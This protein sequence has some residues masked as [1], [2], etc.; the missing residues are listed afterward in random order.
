MITR[1]FITRRLAI[2]DINTTGVSNPAFGAKEV[3]WSTTGEYP[4]QIFTCTQSYAVGN[5]ITIFA[6]WQTYVTNGTFTDSGGNTYTQIYTDDLGDRR[7]V[8][9]ATVITPLISGVSTITFTDGSAGTYS[10][11]TIAILKTTGGSTLDGSIAHAEGYA[12]P[13]PFNVSIPITVSANSIVVGY[14]S[15]NTQVWTNGGSFVLISS[16]TMS[17]GSPYYLIYKVN[18]S[19]GTVNPTGTLTDQDN[20][21]SILT[22]L[23]AP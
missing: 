14:V 8:Y 4:S 22:S 9:K 11:R 19:S 6:Q 20:Y 2:P 12:N 21:F 16:E 18:S 23:I 7:A 3:F 15:T 13:T 10:K 1:R 5:T 17:D